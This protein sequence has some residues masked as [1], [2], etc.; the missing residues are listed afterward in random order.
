MWKE[1]VLI[2]ERQIEKEKREAG[3]IKPCETV[4]EIVDYLS[5]NLK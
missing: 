4:N 3:L 1:I 2:M 5:E